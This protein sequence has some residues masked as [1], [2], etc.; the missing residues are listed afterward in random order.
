MSDLSKS[1]NMSENYISRLFKVETGINIIQY[2]NLIKL[3]KAKELLLIKDNSIK[4]VAYKVGYDTP[5]YFNRLFN[6]LYGINPTDYIQMIEQL[7]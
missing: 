2:I 4:E 1:V 5:S 6:K 3:E 7:S